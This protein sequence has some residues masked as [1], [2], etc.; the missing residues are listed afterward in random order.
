M[1]K[2]EIEK[3]LQGSLIAQICVGVKIRLCAVFDLNPTDE[4]VDLRIYGEG[5][6]WEDALAALS[7]HV[8]K[9]MM[10]IVDR[11]KPTGE[12]TINPSCISID[13]SYYYY[14]NDEKNEKIYLTTGTPPELY[15]RY[16]FPNQKTVLY[17][18]DGHG[19]GSL[20]EEHTYKAAM[21]KVIPQDYE[22][23]AIA[24]LNETLKDDFERC[25]V[26]SD[27][28]YLDF[29]KQQIKQA[30]ECTGLKKEELI[31]LLEDM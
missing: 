12:S 7:Y 26:R 16:C 22:S 14:I 21:D 3:A 31:K 17:G 23:K 18:S 15:E 8:K 13:P 29:A 19:I 10:A 4:M 28:A 30:L 2:E 20:F 24:Y 25:I 11:A 1:T 5:F 9:H 27:G 6:T